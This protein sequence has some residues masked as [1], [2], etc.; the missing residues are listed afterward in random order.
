VTSSTCASCSRPVVEAVTQG[1]PILLQPV[2]R[3]EFDRLAVYVIDE[4]GIAASTSFPKA[5][6][7]TFIRH[8]CPGAGKAAA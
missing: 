2:K 6:A 8:A 5:G 1:K 7:E 4:D 3:G